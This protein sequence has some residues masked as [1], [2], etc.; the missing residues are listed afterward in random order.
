MLKVILA[1]YTDFEDRVRII[2]KTGA[3]R[4]AYDVVKAYVSG[5]VGTFTREE[6]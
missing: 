4:S 2:E 5:K 3:R 6:D 1:C